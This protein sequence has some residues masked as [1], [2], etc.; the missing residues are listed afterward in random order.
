MYGVVLLLAATW[1]SIKQVNLAGS[2]QQD[3]LGSHDYHYSHL[4]DFRLT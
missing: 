2:S 4:T 3:L 1:T